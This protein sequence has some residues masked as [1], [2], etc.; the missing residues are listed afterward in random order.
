MN[1][2]SGSDL[3]FFRGRRK[4]LLFKR[5]FNR[6]YKFSENVD[7]DNNPPPPPPSIDKIKIPHPSVHIKLKL[8]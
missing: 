6:A 8:L 1:D 3:R 2:E 4:N 7:Q 5:Y